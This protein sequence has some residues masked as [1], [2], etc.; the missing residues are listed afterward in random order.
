MGK[1]I[2]HLQPSA[3]KH[4]ALSICDYLEP[5]SYEEHSKSKFWN[6]VMKSELETF[7]RNET[8]ILVDKP[9]H[10]IPWEQVG[11]LSQA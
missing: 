11:L 6:D 3:Q 7:N 1:G 9:A 4:Y 10:V 2:G 8:W 5:T